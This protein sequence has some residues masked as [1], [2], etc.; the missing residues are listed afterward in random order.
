MARHVALGWKV[1]TA[2]VLA[3][4]FRCNPGR[5]PLLVQFSSA[6]VRY[7]HAEAVQSLLAAGAISD[8]VDDCGWSSW[9]ATGLAPRRP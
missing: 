3:P 2:G 8:E 9:Y 5:Q 1:W 7:G 4:P 6:A